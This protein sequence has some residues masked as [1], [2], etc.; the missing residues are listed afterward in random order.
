MTLTY[1]G[2]AIDENLRFHSSSG[3]ITTAIVKYLF[4]SGYINTALACKFDEQKCQYTPTLIYSYNDYVMVGSVYQDLD[5]I[6]F[7]RNHINKIR[8]RIFVV[9]APCQVKAI[10]SILIKNNIENV[11]INYFCSG[12]TTIEGTYK[13]YELLGLNKTNIKNI[14]YRGDGWPNGITIETKEGDIIKRPNYSE[15]W[16][17]LHQ[18]HLYRPRR[19]S[20]CKIMESEDADLSVGDPWLEDYMEHEK[21]GSNLFLVH[22]EFGFELIKKMKINNLIEINEVGYD[23]FMKS[24]RPNIDAK[25]HIPD[26]IKI[27]ERELKLFN[28]PR[29]FMWAS[30]CQS[31]MKKHMKLMQYVNFYYKSKKKLFNKNIKSFTNNILQKLKGGWKRKLAKVG[32]GCY[33]GRNVTMQNSS[34]IYLGNNVG[35]G[36]YTYFL[37]CTY[38]AGRNYSPKIIVGD[39]TWIGIRNSFAAINGIIIGKNVLFAGYVHVTDHSQGYEDI[40]TPIIQQPLISKGPVIIEDNCWLGFGC[41]ILS[42]VHIGKHCV[43]AA[44]AV[45]TKDVPPYSIVAGN[46]ARIIKQYNTETQTWNKIKNI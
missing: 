21:I 8:G 41:E 28:N 39:N 38:Y 33:K 10:R 11:I 44:R 37:P 4:D 26:K 27:L 29:Y 40:H 42:G 46:P 9:C 18:S 2:Y 32:K 36:S 6:G 15:P 12:Q 34:C 7:I 30:S 16:K 1:I 19:C 3:G 43:V 17:T 22:S 35:I 14:R 20:Y 5:V 45:V 25:R 13:Y 24:Q 31:N 23:L